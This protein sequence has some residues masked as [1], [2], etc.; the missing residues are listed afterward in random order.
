MAK[1]VE[2][3]MILQGIKICIFTKQGFFMI[4]F[5]T[6]RL[7]VRLLRMGDFR[8][9]YLWQSDVEILRYTEAHPKLSK[10][11]IQ[12]DLQM[13]IEGYAVPENRLWLWAIEDK[14][15]N[16]VGNLRFG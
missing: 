10:E 1:I 3:A 12:T 8:Q 4:L 6:E 5:D 14:A 9:F 7:K 11:A 16:F 2:N 13:L 15:G